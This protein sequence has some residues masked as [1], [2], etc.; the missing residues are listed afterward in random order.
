MPHRKK[1]HAT[2]KYLHSVIKEVQRE[3]LMDW[4]EKQLARV[5]KWTLQGIK[6]ILF[7]LIMWVVLHFVV[8]R[9]GGYNLLDTAGSDRI[10]HME[11]LQRIQELSEPQFVPSSNS[12][13]QT[14]QPAQN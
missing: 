11:L 14:H 9:V 1:H 13:H 10:V 6:T 2:D 12:N 5:G 3:I 7:Y 8:I 4:Y